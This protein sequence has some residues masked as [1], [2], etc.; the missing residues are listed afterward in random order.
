MDRSLVSCPTYSGSVNDRFPTP[1]TT[2]IVPQD[3]VVSSVEFVCLNT[4]SIRAHIH[5]VAGLL[6]CL[7]AH[8]IVS[9]TETWLDG[10]Y[11]NS[12]L[13]RSHSVFRVDRESRQGG[14]SVVLVPHAF[15]SSM[16]IAP[17]CSDDFESI[18]V[19]TRLSTTTM[20]LVSVYRRPGSCCSVELIEYLESALATTVPVIVVGDFNL[21]NIDWNT[22]TALPRAAPAERQ[23]L[24]CV[25]TQGLEQLVLQPTR[26][27][28]ILDLVLTNRPG[29]VHSLTVSPPIIPSDH[30]M[31]T[32]DV[33]TSAPTPCGVSATFRNFKKG[34]YGSM[35]VY[36]AQIDWVALFE[37]ESTAQGMWDV[38]TNVVVAAINIFVP[39]CTRQQRLCEHSKEVCK[40][41][42][43]QRTLH[44]KFKRSGLDVDREQWKII[45]RQ[46][47]TAIRHSASNF[48]QKVIA[49][50]D[51]SKFWR[52]VSSRLKINNSVAALNAN[53]TLQTS[54]RDKAKAL[55]DQFS[56]VFIVDNG[57]KLNL[58]PCEVREQCDLREIDEVTLFGVLSHLPNKFSSG[59]DGLPQFLLKRLAISVAEPLTFIFNFSLAT[60]QLPTDWTCANI[61]PIFKKGLPSE[62]SNYRPIS[63]TS[64]TCRAF[65]KIVKK[66]IL[67][68]L[69][70]NGTLTESQHGF[71]S[72][73]STITQL[74][75]CMSDWTSSLDNSQPVDVAYMDIA[76]AFDTVSHKKLLE[77]LEFYGI[78]GR[79]LG[80]LKA[81]LSGRK[82]RVRIDDSYSSSADVGS[83]VPQGSVLGP[84]LFLIYIND[85]PKAVSHCKLKLFA[86]D[87]KIY[88]CVQTVAQKEFFQSDLAAIKEWCD[89]NQLS[90]AI[91]KC[92]I[93]HL[94][95]RANPRYT[96]VLGGSELPA[97]NC[98]RDLGV[99][100]SPDLRF[101]EHCNN[102]AHSAAVKTNLVFNSFCNR[103]PSFLLQLYKT[104]VRSRLEYATPV[105]SPGTLQNIETVES[106]QRKFTRRLPGMGALTYPQRLIVANLESLELR[107]IHY[108]LILVYKIVHQKIALNFDDYF[109]LAKST[110]TR[111]HTYKLEV[112][113][114]KTNISKFFFANRVV[115][116]WNSLSAETV[117]SRTIRTF[118]VRLNAENLSKLLKVRL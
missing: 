64:A 97:T 62:P 108:D 49:S 59:P 69:L 33:I 3:R 39:L 112:P 91:I 18:V 71:L 66:E 25:I 29:F 41:V 109:K 77:K 46:C 15:D 56:S 61:T 100:I 28:N 22:L 14:G 24:N 7:L 105:W 111:G 52:F 4:Q 37:A 10:S 107:R 50:G 73:H 99:L 103:S 101:T 114:C 58:G 72:N 81:W 70:R 36:L 92:S 87:C 12:L 116:V 6:S 26:H 57:N 68:H 94:G 93:L 102:V 40:L 104:F 44:T 13:S 2:A 89:A 16:P 8:S 117:A 115:P 42:R 96:Y 43:K 76:K 84:L 48:E 20:R 78:S 32:F 82:Q 17:L 35:N 60:S 67:N 65:E 53:G 5:D 31:V 51:E 88:L 11:S 79:L 27:D 34:D 85:L 75:E 95:P 30:Q 118:K 23:L 47:R 80:W 55:N 9:F 83:G 98:V 90:L 21:P 38:F 1:S 63:I 86:D 106:V 54:N 45:S 19:D 113:R 74:L 110:V